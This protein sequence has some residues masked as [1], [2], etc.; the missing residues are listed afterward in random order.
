ML[1]SPK[2][3]SF[4]KPNLS[5]KSL[6]ALKVLLS[7]LCSSSLFLLWVPCLAYFPFL[8]QFVFVFLFFHGFLGLPLLFWTF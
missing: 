8:I 2:W 5:S 1:L 3:G 4:L 6:L 7:C